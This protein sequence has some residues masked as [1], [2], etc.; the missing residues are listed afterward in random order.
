VTELPPLGFSGVPVDALRD[1]YEK[2]VE[3]LRDLLRSTPS[4][5][6]H[7]SE[8]KQRRDYLTDRIK[9]VR[10]ILS[11]YDVYAQADDAHKMMAE[12]RLRKHYIRFIS[13]NTEHDPETC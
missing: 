13:E 5:K 12:L 2:S 1:F 9:Q 3:Y 4:E 7:M 10:N 11:E 8:F 6:Q